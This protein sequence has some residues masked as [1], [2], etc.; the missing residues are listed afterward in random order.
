M[1]AAV[2]Q[3]VDDVEQKLTADVVP[4][5]GRVASRL[6]QAHGDVHLDR[7]FRGPGVEREHVGGRRIVVEPS[8]QVGHL[9]VA[10]DADRESS[11]LPRKMRTGRLDLPA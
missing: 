9:R 2:Q 10:D 11:H 3:T 7:P 4:A 1:T 8:M 5:F 6:V